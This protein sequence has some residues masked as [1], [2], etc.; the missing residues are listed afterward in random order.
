MT[1]ALDDLEDMIDKKIIGIAVD[2]DTETVSIQTENGLIE[3]SGHG[4][5]IYTEIDDKPNTVQ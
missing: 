3:L 5:T 1:D 2:G 4:L